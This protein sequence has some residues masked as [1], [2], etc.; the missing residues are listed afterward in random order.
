MKSVTIDQPLPDVRLHETYVP[1]GPD[2]ENHGLEPTQ[3]TYQVDQAPEAVLPV[4]ELQDGPEG[5]GDGEE[6]GGVAAAR[7]VGTL[8][9]PQGVAHHVRQD[10]GWQH[11]HL[12][13]EHA[14]RHEQ[15]LRHSGLNRRIVSR[16]CDL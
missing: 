15:E 12:G 16:R 11:A 4:E 3:A 6:H 13:G 9:Q 5:E 7:R 2:R 10:G 8:Q 14:K 1:R